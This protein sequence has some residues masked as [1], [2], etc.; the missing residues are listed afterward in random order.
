VALSR[1]FRRLTY[2]GAADDRGRTPPVFAD[3]PAPTILSLSAGLPPMLC[4]LGLLFLAGR[5]RKGSYFLHNI[6][7]RGV[8][9]AHAKSRRIA[10]R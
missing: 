3:R 4:A 7:Y 1:D 8:F 9:P 5:P 6:D 10:L 2:P